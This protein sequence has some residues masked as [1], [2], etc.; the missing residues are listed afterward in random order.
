MSVVHA[1]LIVYAVTMVGV[2][3]VRVVSFAELD[4]GMLRQCLHVPAR[5]EILR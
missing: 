4:C 5:V 2:D 1:G 3:T